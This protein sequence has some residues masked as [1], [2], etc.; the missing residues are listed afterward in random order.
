MEIKQQLAFMSQLYH[1]TNC[2]NGNFNNC[3]SSIC[4]NNKRVL[5]ITE[6]HE[7]KKQLLCG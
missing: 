6:T 4:K 5:G 7:S 3:Q 2:N 1:S